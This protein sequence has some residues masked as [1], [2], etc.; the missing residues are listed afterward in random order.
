M[1]PSLERD[2]P[3]R[4][5]RR[6][7]GAFTLVELLVVI[8]IIAVLIAIL[9]PVLK[10]AKDAANR[11][12]CTSNIRQ[13][14]AACIL[15]SQENR[16]YFPNARIHGN[17][18][19]STSPQA[20]RYA[21]WIKPEPARRLEDSAI[22][23]YLSGSSASGASALRKVLVCPGDDGIRRT[24][25]SNP[26]ATGVHWPSYAMHRNLALH[27]FH[28][29][30]PDR[31]RKYWIHKVMLAEVD[32][33]IDQ[34][35]QVWRSMLGTDRDPL[36]NGDNRVAR[37]HGTKVHPQTGRRMGYNASVAFFDGHVE[38]M[39]DWE[40]SENHYFRLDVTMNQRE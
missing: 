3:G 22:A 10:K 23:R 40:I 2:N 8:A 21:D 33:P 16:G 38:A 9:L 29:R 18:M 37:T 30:K 32:D 6:N 5:S 28:Q 25:G 4:A 13:L 39:D 17:D 7:A 19:K 20:G 36:S 31:G 26:G 34:V 14:A 27:W 15:Y 35:W 24:Y 1:R 11:A 12:V